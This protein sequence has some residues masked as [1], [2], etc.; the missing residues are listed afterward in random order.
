MRLTRLHST[1][2]SNAAS[3]RALVLRSFVLTA[4]AVLTRKQER[5][6]SEGHGWCSVLTRCWVGN[7]GVGVVRVVAVWSEGLTL[8]ATREQQ[9]EVKDD[10][11]EWNEMHD[12]PRSPHVEVLHPTKDVDQTDRSRS[13]HHEREHGKL[14][15]RVGELLGGW[16]D[17]EL[18]QGAEGEEVDDVQT[19]RCILFR[20]P[21]F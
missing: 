9:H 16:I 7:P 8:H 17:L 5:L 12:D 3:W 14:V 10:V 21:S 13:N 19:R 4:P 11:Q 18:E 15:A 6:T 1:Q 2:A 20:Y